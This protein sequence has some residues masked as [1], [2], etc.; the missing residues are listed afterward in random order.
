MSGRVTL[1]VQDHIGQIVLDRP[2]KMNAITPDMTRELQ[3][4]CGE[5][6]NATWSSILI[7]DDLDV[8]TLTDGVRIDYHS[9]RRAPGVTSRIQFATLSQDPLLIFYPDTSQMGTFVSFE[10]IDSM[11]FSQVM[12]A[13]GEGQMIEIEASFNY[14]KLRGYGDSNDEFLNG[15]FTSRV[16]PRN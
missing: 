4:V 9:V 5:L 6:R 8:P 2:D 7:C 14:R 15:T 10:D 13:N 11:T 1:T 16:F 12:A 3:R